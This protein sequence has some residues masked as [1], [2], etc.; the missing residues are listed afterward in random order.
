MGINIITFFNT[1]A[2]LQTKKGSSDI[3][4]DGLNWLK[5]GIIRL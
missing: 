1:T 2:F 4:S 3:W 5:F